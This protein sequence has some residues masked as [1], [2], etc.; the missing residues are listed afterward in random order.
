MEF[1]PQVMD[2]LKVCKG[3]SESTHKTYKNALKRFKEFYGSKISNFLDEFGEDRRKKVPDHVG[4]RNLRNFVDFLEKKGYSSKT[5]HTYV[6]A[7]QSL[8]RYI[9]RTSISTKYINLPSPEAESKKYEWERKEIFELVQ[10]LNG[11]EMKAITTALYQSGLSISD[12]LSLKW[13]DI[14]EQYEE[15]IV[16]ICIRGKRLKTSEPFITFLGR[17]STDKLREHIEEKGVSGEKPIFSVNYRT[18]AQRFE[19]VAPHFVGEYEGT[20]PCRPHSLRSAFVT[21]LTDAGLRGV[22]VEFFSGHNVAD[23]VRKTYQRRSR[24]KWR[25]K[26][27]QYEW[28]ITPPQVREVYGIEA[29][30]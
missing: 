12:L 15:G 16:P 29:P 22:I 1:C 25:E 28:A 4:E 3:R 21:H 30:S 27:E 26:Y 5:I 13:E 9:Y 18:I 19:R 23:D 7:V 10:L 24:K 2:F 14:K 17:W 20:N 6:A 8:V 11:K